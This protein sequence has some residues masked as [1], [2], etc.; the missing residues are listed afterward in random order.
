MYTT[1]NLVEDYIKRDLEANEV[2]L[3][4]T[5]IIPAVKQYIDRYLGTT[6]DSASAT[7]RYF[8]GGGQTVDID[9]CTTITAVAFV[10]SELVSYGDV[11]DTDYVAYPINE[12]VKTYLRFRTY[13]PE[14]RLSSIKVTATFT[15]YDGEVPGDITLAATMLAAAMLDQGEDAGVTSESIEG[16]SIS[17]DV[18][19]K[20]TQSPVIHNI[21][22]LRKQILI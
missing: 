16:H 19:A 15:E 2:T 3:L 4:E 6:F 9:P 22:E 13:R 11:E 20:A 12:D 5:A 1:E 8:D 17:Y 10:D 21:L 18:A 7:S 14:H